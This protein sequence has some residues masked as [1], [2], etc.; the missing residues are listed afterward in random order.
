MVAFLNY[1]DG[2]N[3]YLKVD[4]SGKIAGA[5]SFRKTSYE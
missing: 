1:R 4:D 3:I 5:L 2:G